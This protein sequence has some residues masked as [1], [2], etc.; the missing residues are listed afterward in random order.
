MVM[1]RCFT[2]SPLRSAKMALPA[3]V[4]DL[5]S[6]LAVW[7]IVLHSALHFVGTVKIWLYYATSVHATTTTTV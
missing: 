4:G 6:C 2:P 7:Q 1:T 3:S 5:A